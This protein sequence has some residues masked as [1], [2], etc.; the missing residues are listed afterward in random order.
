M[1]KFIKKLKI[2]QNVSAY[3]LV[4]QAQIHAHFQFLQGLFCFPNY[5]LKGAMSAA[6]APPPLQGDP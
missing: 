2:H 6:P 5:F 4:W 1:L 3:C